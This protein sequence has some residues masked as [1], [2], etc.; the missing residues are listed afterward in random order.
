MPSCYN[1]LHHTIKH[2]IAISP[3]PILELVFRC[4]KVWEHW[5]RLQITKLPTDAI[6]LCV[7]NLV[8]MFYAPH[9]IS[10]MTDSYA[11]TNCTVNVY[12]KM[13]GGKRLMTSYS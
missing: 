2:M 3:F 12:A 4:I 6:L 13:F 10:L 9:L 11:H 1:T 8:R 5:P 7:R